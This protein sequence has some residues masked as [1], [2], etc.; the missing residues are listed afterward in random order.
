[1][2]L[3]G[4][5]PINGPQGLYPNQWPSEAV[6]QSMALR[7]C[8][9]IN[10]PREPYP[11]CVCPWEFGCKGYQLIPCQGSGEGRR[12]WGCVSDPRGPPGSGDWSGTSGTGRP[13]A[14][15]PRKDRRNR[16]DKNRKGAFPSSA[17]RY[18]RHRTCQTA[19]PECPGAPS[20]DTYDV[21]LRCTQCLHFLSFYPSKIDVVFFPCGRITK[22]INRSMLWLVAKTDFPCDF[23]NSHIELYIHVYPS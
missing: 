6:S 23:C 14:S 18:L 9:P 17:P 11:R 8:I 22:A 7:E 16:S 1:M 21:S 10:V 19:C 4:C 2:I 13:E 12:P 3:R 15:C 5:I 20:C